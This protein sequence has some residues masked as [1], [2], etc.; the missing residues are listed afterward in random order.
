MEQNARSRTTVRTTDEPAPTITGSRDY[1]ER[2]WVERF[3]DQSGT[4]VDHLWP[5]RRPATAIA[6]RGLVQ[7]PGETSN[8]F[9]T[10]TKSRND[11]VRVTVQEAATLQTFPPDYPWAGSLTS[12]FQQVGDAIPPTL[13]RAILAEVM[14]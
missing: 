12:R 7:N 11:G 5:T 6:G 2:V 8:R 10:S 4:P 14:P 3:R 9:N 1:G 13:A